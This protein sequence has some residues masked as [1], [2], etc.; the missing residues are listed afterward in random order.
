MNKVK[1][2]VITA[3]SAVLLGTCAAASASAFAAEAK[4]ASSNEEATMPPYETEFTVGGWVQFYDVNKRSYL[5]QVED[6]AR[7]GMNLIDLPLSVSGSVNHSIYSDLTQFYKDLDELCRQ[8][9]MYYFYMENYTGLEFQKAWQTVQ[10]LSEYCLGYHLKD[11]PSAAQMDALAAICK[12]FKDADPLRMPYVNLFPNYAGATNL[13]GTYR[14][15]VNKWVSV[16]GGT[17]DWLYFDHYP[18][19]QFEDV[20][21]TYFSDLEVIRDV[22]Y[23][24]G[25]IKTGGFTQMGSWN[26]MRRPTPDMARWSMNSLLTYGMKSIS[27]FCWVAPQYVAPENGGEGMR[28]F[29]L[30]AAGE[31]TDLYEPMTVLNWQTRQ[32]G[33]I[34]MNIDVKHA[35]HTGKAPVGTETL[36]SG[37]VLQPG[38]A[39]DSFVYSIAYSKDTDEPYLLVF[40]KALSGS[41]KEYSFNVD[42]NTGVRNLRYYKPTD[43]T[44][45][46]LPDPRN[47][48]STLFSPEEVVTD[49][50]SGSFTD[51]FLPGEMKIYKLEGEN[52]TIFEDLLAPE[53]THA[54]GVYIGQQTISL[55]TADIGAEIYYTLDGSFPN[56]GTAGTYLYTAPFTVGNDGETATYSVRALCVRGNEV[57]NILDLDLI[58]ADASRNVAEGVIGKFMSLDMSEEIGFSG[59]N[60]SSTNIRNLTDGSFDPTGSVLATDEIGWAVIDLGSEQTVDRIVFS[61]WHDWWFGS[62]KVQVARNADFSDAYTV[63]EVSSMQNAANGGM[64][65]EFEP[66]Q[67]HYVRLTN[68]TKGEGGYSLFTEVQVFSAYN[69]GENLISD[70]E[71]WSNVGGGNFTNDGT[72]I[73][74][75]DEYQRVNWDKAFSYNAK[76]YKN[77]MIDVTMSIDVGAY[78]AWGYVGFQIF[79]ESV[80]V[81]QS[82]VGRGYIVGIEPRGRA[83]VWTGANEIG[84][85]DANVVGWSLG[86]KFDMKVVVYNGIISVAVNGRPVMNVNLPEL[87][88]KSGYI[89]IHGGTLPLTVYKLNITELGDDFAFPQKGG[90]VVSVDNPKVAVERYIPENKVIEKLGDKVTVTDTAGKNYVVGVTWTG[91]GYDRSKTGNFDFYGVL[92]AQDLA[93]YGLSNVYGVKAA[94]TVFIKSEI[95]YS[96]IN[97]LLDLA[98]TLNS[99]EYTAESWDYLQLK[100]EAAESI[101]ADEFLVQSDVNVGMFQLYDAIYKYLVYIGDTTELNTAIA[102]AS[103][104]KENEYTAYSFSDFVKVLEEVTEYNEGTFKTYAGV[105]ENIRKLKVA[106]SKLVKLNVNDE[107][108]GEK[109]SLEPTKPSS[110]SGVKGCNSSAGSASAAG[111][112]VVTVALA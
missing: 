34:L 80:D 36:P 101:L 17:L 82:N 23:K 94:G 61:M 74:N 112:G 14:D 7:D 16:N 19:T 44:M 32:L 2:V 78:D 28:D 108:S 5:D 100:A 105:N 72:V 40:N 68:D 3:L 99:Y 65:I 51:V 31:K 104:L 106:E 73:S 13:G 56:P 76:T 70:V 71:N 95:D 63:F 21:S 50:S 59:F 90:A 52:V 22:A 97:G 15:Y 37:F 86:G 79:R 39:A 89:S 24:N 45:E 11:E 85:L 83:L 92:S 75:P 27:H 26:G 1:K 66:M 67:I 12:E 25:K 41:A 98:K 43:Y 58:I 8:I 96:V 20:R 84:P 18:F 110:S 57:S 55:L 103:A 88:G 29:V 35:Y 6:L 60:G 30:T 38:S 46:T 33:N 53:S 4:D 109:P 10:Y 77:F 62:V 9:D 81:V 102:E 48:A 47:L 64:S 93:A 87:S 91:D 42:L 54:S 111:I 69:S 107:F 49:V